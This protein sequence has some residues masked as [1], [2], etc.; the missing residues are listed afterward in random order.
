M[1]IQMEVN[2]NINY[3]LW[4]E[5]IKN[6][7]KKIGLELFNFLFS[8]SK[9]IYINEE[10]I[11]ILVDDFTLNFLQKNSENYINFKNNCESILYKNDFDLIFD[12]KDNEHSLSISRIND[13]I[14]NYKVYENSS[15]LSK[16]DNTN[17]QYEQTKLSSNMTFNN[18][19]YSYENKQVVKAAQILISEINNPTFNP[20]FIYGVSGIGKTHILNAIGNEIYNL[21]ENRNILYLH[22]T[23]FIEEYTSL[24]KGGITNTEKIEEFKNKYLN[25]DVL[26]ID[27]IQ[28]LESKEG[29]L[30][31]FFGIFEKLKNSNKIIIIASDKH[32]NKINFEDRL[33]SRFLS[34][35]NCEIKL[36]DTDTKKQIFNHHALER[37]INVEDDAINV[38]ID[39][40][41]NVRTLLG[42]LNSITISLISNDF[43]NSTIT[44]DDAI[45]IMNNTNGNSHNLTENDIIKV[46]TNHFKVSK[47]ELL[48]KSR[49][50]N[51]VDARHFSAYFLRDC[52]KI[53]H[54]RISYILKFQ[55]HS[56]ALNAIKSVKKKIRSEKYQKDYNQIKTLLNT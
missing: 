51:I 50:K 17:Y 49:K 31:E 25:I 19:F 42:Y 26:L 53:K 20:L 38:F 1:K 4:N 40:S 8:E 27:D 37:D 18:F 46:V 7:K 36:P 47:T 15:L 33:I 28:L 23:T 10:K 43:E 54:Q 9:P 32:P 13:D 14:T 3:E 34:G 39:N 11:I 45:K 12:S 48:S 41:T 24:F 35:L 22:S 6:H 55:D 44:K 29:S 2:R 5:I 56:A 52:L 16:N 21:N 30:N